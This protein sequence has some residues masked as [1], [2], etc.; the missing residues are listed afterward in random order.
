[1]IVQKYK[2]TG[3]RSLFDEHDNYQKL[4]SI[5][6]PLEKIS[7]VV[8][9]ELFRGTLEKGILNKDKRNNAGAKPFDVVMMFKILILQRFYGLGDTQY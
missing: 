2:K 6:N 5:S 1:M 8:D 4:S 3:N 9:F 7:L